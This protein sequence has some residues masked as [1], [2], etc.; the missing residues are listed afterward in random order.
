MQ[1]TPGP[2]MPTAVFDVSQTK[3]Q[4]IAVLQAGIL[5]FCTFQAALKTILTVIKSHDCTTPSM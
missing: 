3:T 1:L 2:T 4:G 5:V